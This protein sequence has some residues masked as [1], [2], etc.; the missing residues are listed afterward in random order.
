VTVINSLLFSKLWHVMR[1]FTFSQPEIKQLQQIAA[2]FI[3]K[4]AKLTRFS[5]DFLTKPIKQGGLKLLGPATQAQALQWRWVYPLLHPQQTSPSLMPSIPVLR[6]TL[7][8]V[9]S[10]PQYPSY[11]WSLLFPSCR[12]VIPR[13]FGPVRNIIRSVD[14]LPHDFHFCYATMSTC[15]HLPIMELLV[16]TIPASHPLSPTFQPPSSVLQQHPTIRHLKGS[17]LFFFNDT[18]LHLEFHHNTRTLPHRNS[19]RK[20]ISLIQANQLLLNNFVLYNFIPY[21]PRP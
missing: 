11:H 4:G 2:S 7:D 3:N 16:H 13:L 9:L 17:D 21:V 15:L 8:Y 19:S 18:T 14:S 1:L 12:P 5:F 6:F 10:S 20:A